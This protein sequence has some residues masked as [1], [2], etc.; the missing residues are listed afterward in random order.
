MSTTT[1]KPTFRGAA[2]RRSISVSQESL[3]TIAQLHDRSTLPMVVT[4]TV[5]GL[6]LTTWA[7]NNRAQVEE[8]V[9]KHGGVLFRGFGV[10][11]SE[12]L[13]QFVSA[14][15]PQMLEYTYRSTPR[16]QVVGKI[17]TS[18]EYPADQS[19]PFHNEMSYT[20]TWP[21]KIWF[22]CLKA[23]EQGGETPI[24]DSRRVFESLDPSIRQRFIDKRVMYVRN[25]GAGLDLSWQNVFQTDSRTEVEAFC[26]SAGIDFEWKGEDGLRTRQVCQSIAHHPKTGEVVWFNQAHL[27]HVSSLP[28]MVRDMLLAE[29]KEEDLPRNTYYGDGTPIEPETLDAIRAAF[30]ENAVLFPWQEGDVLMLDNMLVAHARSPFVG[31]RK[32]VVGMAESYSVEEETE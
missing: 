13:E 32:V 14:M 19:I 28:P 30:D 26:R 12:E 24:A 31:A 29:F 2:A 3:V 1:P 21:M 17:Y 25:Y 9:L 16:S 6:N 7:T 22:C 20:S 4:P 5:A 18:T 23:A 10:R 8:M 15:S 27:F 11:S